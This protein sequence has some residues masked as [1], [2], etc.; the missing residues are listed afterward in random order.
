LTKR[1]AYVK[2]K[3]LEDLV[4]LV[5][6]SL[7]PIIQHTTI[8]NKHVYFIQSVP[9]LGRPLIYFFESD[10]EIEK[11]YIIYNKFKDEISFSDKL[12]TDGQS[13]SI[14]ILEVEKT[15]LLKKIYEEE[16]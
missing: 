3:R 13:V 9:L 7:T 11:R 6:L 16:T 12:S 5:A 10:D 1:L 8:K 4:R 14:P 15:N 2:F